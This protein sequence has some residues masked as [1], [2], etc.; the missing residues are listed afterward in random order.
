MPLHFLGSANILHGDMHSPSFL[1]S[2]ACRK[3]SMW[4]VGRGLVLSTAYL[5]VVTLFILVIFAVSPRCCDSYA[6]RTP[7]G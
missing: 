4:G 7:F 2:P 5:S 3:G 1:W 6:A